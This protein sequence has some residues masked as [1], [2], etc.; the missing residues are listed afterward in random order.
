M[1]ENP[2]RNKQACVSC[3]AIIPEGRSYC[4]FCYSSTD[5][6]FTRVISKGQSQASYSD[7]SSEDGLLSCLFDISF[8]KYA[9]L[10]LVRFLYT[11]SV[12]I[13]VLLCFFG[14]Y[15]TWRF[16]N[17]T[18]DFQFFQDSYYSARFKLFIGSSLFIG[19]F[20]VPIFLLLWIRVSLEFAIAI[21]KTAENTGKMLEFSKKL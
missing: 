19:S 4:P 15:S 16:F 12:L 5:N 10:Y 17:D 18:A 20:L 11:I 7:S 21:I 6:R 9:I 3:G 14:L 13:M 1:Q 8:N 2:R